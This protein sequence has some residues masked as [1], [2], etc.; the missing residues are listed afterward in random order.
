MEEKYDHDRADVYSNRVRAGKRT[1]FFDVKSTRH[2]EFYITITESKKRFLDDGSP[3]FEKH[4]IFLYREDFRKFV[5]ALNLALDK[6]KEVAPEGDH[7]YEH[8]EYTIEE[9]H[10]DRGDVNSFRTDQ[11]ADGEAPAPREHREPREYRPQEGYNRGG[12]GGYRQ[13]GGGGYQGGGYGQNNSGGS[14]PG[15]GGYPRY[16]RNQGGSQGAPERYN[17]GDRYSNNND[18]Y[19]RGGGGGGGYQG[20]DRYNR[21]GGGGYQGGQDSG[22]NGGDWNR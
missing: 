13:G 1:Y 22:N 14:N 20:G 4:K 18:R 12:G 3:V 7:P 2:S 11:P 16:E 8:D 6:V 15:P 10:F 21:G 17:R 19:N 9:R 5:A